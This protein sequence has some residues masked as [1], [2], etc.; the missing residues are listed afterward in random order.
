MSKHFVF[1]GA[2]GSGKGTQAERL[3]K[4][5][6]YHH[7]STGNLL[8]AEVAKASELGKIVEQVLKD[9]QLVTDDLVK[10]LLVANVDLNKPSVFDGYPRTLVQAKVLSEIL[11]DQDYTVVYFTVNVD[12][13]VDRLTSRLTC[14]DCGAIYNLKTLKPQNEG[15]CDHCQGHNLK[16]RADDTEEVVRERQEVYKENITPVLDYFKEAGKLVELNAS[17]PIE[18]IYKEVLRLI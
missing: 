11:K 17:R 3:I 15:Q 10:D 9:G 6:G 7:I 2:P 4:E 12:D 1:I 5:N 16:Q 8:R 18:E 14:G 13:I